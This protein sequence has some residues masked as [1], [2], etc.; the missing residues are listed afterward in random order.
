MRSEDLQGAHLGGVVLHYR[1]IPL[2]KVVLSLSIGQVDECR[3]RDVLVLLSKH[4]LFEEQRHIDSFRLGLRQ[5]VRDVSVFIEQ[6]VLLLDGFVAVLILS[7]CVQFIDGE[8]V[9]V[10][11]FD[12]LG[13]QSTASWTVVVA[14]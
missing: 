13:Q 12:G 5:N 3:L 1:I 4:L 9:E 11:Q 2:K 6:H 10:L 7:R 8:A 14:S